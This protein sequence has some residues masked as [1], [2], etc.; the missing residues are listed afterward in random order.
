MEGG[1]GCSAVWQVDTGHHE[2]WR[3]KRQIDGNEEP[4]G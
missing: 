4:V 1:C 3:R 2:D